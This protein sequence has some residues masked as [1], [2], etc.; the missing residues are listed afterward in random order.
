MEN[1][2][3]AKEN[4]FIYKGEF[5]EIGDLSIDTDYFLINVDTQE[6]INICICNMKKTS[7]ES[8]YKIKEKYYV[9]KGFSIIEN[10]ITEEEA[11][12]FIELATANIK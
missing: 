2:I 5:Y 7:K 10:F 1:E 11:K 6:E 12:H 9:K 8:L 4:G 3:V